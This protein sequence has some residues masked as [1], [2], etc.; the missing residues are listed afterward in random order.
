M[1]LRNPDGRRR[2]ICGTI[3]D[4]CVGVLHGLVARNCGFDLHVQRS[5]IVHIAGVEGS[6]EVM[7]CP[8][9]G[10]G[11]RIRIQN[12]MNVHAACDLLGRIHAVL[13]GGDYRPVAFVLR[14]AAGD[15]DLA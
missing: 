10:S 15:V 8:L 6:Q 1:A 4:H 2:R 3:A 14:P 5:A 12:P 9:G 7:P 13:R 11:A